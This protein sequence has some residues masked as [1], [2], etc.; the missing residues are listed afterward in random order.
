MK[1]LNIEKEENLNEPPVAVPTPMMENDNIFYCCTECSSSI[2]ILSINKDMNLIEFKC[3]NK[4]HNDVKKMK[5][6][7]YFEKMEK[8]KK[9]NINQDICINHSYKK[10]VGYCFDCNKHLCEECLVE[11]EH[12]NHYKNYLLEIKPIK[13]ELDIINEI[14][15]DYKVKI[16]NLKNQRIEEKRELE[17][18]LNII[19][20]KE[21]ERIKEIININEKNK[22]KELYLNYNKY[23]SDIELIKKKYEKELKD[24]KCE[25]IK[26]ENKI[27]NKYKEKEKEEYIIHS[28]KIEELYKKYNNQIE[29]LEYDKKI[30]NLENVKKLSEIVYNTYNKYNNNYFNSI[31]INNILLIYYKDEYLRNIIMK[32]IS[33]NNLKDISKIIFKRKDNTLNIKQFHEKEMD[34]KIN[35]IKEEYEN[36]EKKIIEE[37]NKERKE[38]QKK[39]IK[40]CELEEKKEKEKEKIIKKYKEKEDQKIEEIYER[41]DEELVVCGFLD[42]NEVK[43]KIKELNY[44]YKLISEW[45][46]EQI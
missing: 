28:I 15:K 9:S 29:Q 27:E 19:K 43:D 44:D 21:E 13:E 34:L 18:R 3:L 38:R 25:Y 33:K 2:E 37:L 12:I 6:N 11:R 36:R 24:R 14:I 16:E 42:E 41:L 23:K 45:A 20:G 40:I 10:Y 46:K 17:N 1:N 26:D 31:N 35:K 22:N 32:N 39:E 4:A 5:I 30:E 8:Y 7:E